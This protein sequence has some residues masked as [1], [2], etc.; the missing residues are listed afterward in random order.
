MKKRLDI[1]VAL[2]EGWE[3]FRLAPSALLGA[4]AIAIIGGMLLTSGILAPPLLGGLLLMIDRL[5]R[6]DPAPL[7]ATNVLLGFA[8]FLQPLL[9]ALGWLV[10][11]G[12]SWVLWHIPLLA[13]LAIIPCLVLLPALFWAFFLTILR[14]ETALDAYRFVFRYIFRPD[15]AGTYFA[16]LLP[17][18]VACAGAILFMVGAIVTMPIGLCMALRV[19]RRAFED[20]PDVEIVFE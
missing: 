2:R 6:D 1:I 10:P 20:E 5:D 13:P 16:M 7:S 15:M 9:V 8:N 17:A 3:L 11:M 4:G 14:R 19:Y 18:L 12:L